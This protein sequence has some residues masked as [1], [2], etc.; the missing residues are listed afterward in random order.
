MKYLF[1][2]ILS[3]LLFVNQTQ[4]QVYSESRK[5]IEKEFETFKLLNPGNQYEEESAEAVIIR[6]PYFQEMLVFASTQYP[7]KQS[8]EDLTQA[9]QH[10]MISEDFDWVASNPDLYVSYVVFDGQGTL[11][12]NFRDVNNRPTQEYKVKEGTLMISVIDSDTGKAVWQGFSD[13][14]LDSNIT[15][16]EAI[17][18]VSNVMDRFYLDYIG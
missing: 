13:G 3:S 16:E 2:L 18:A 17:K 14:A 11:K 5:G 8:K 12:G 15:E 9:V 7:D 6:D 10:E 1:S 4:A